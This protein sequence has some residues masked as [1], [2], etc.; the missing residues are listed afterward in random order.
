MNPLYIYHHGTLF[1]YGNTILSTPRVLVFPIPRVL[2]SPP[3]SLTRHQGALIVTRDTSAVTI[4]PGKGS[5]NLTNASDS[6]TG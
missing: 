6:G 4:S 1:D 5:G 2:E 3:L